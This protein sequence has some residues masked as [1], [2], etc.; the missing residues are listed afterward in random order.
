MN[1]NPYG[2]LEIILGPMFSGKT[3]ELIRLYHNYNL[4]GIPVCVINYYLDTRYDTVKLSTH[5]R[6]MI[7]CIQLKSLR[8]ITQEVIHSND[9]FLINEV[10]FFD[11]DELQDVVL[12][13]V[14]NK[15]KTVYLCGLDGT[16]CREPFQ[17]M[18][19]LKLIPKAD[20]VRKLQ[21]ICTSCKKR[22]APFTMR[23][24]KDKKEVL[25]GSEQYR[26]VCRSCFQIYHN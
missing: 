8:E 19:L 21:A 15:S 14:E 5:D 11:S 26:A 3:S 18:G 25:I 1:L 6:K 13:L 24:G 22:K 7:D 12:D 4:C 23:V 17:G 20:N 16:F 2:Y 10:Q 9:V